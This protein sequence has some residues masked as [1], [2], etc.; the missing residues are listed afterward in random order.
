MSVPPKKLE[1]KVWFA[2]EVTVEVAAREAVRKEQGA[3]IRADGDDELV[4]VAAQLDLCT[5]HERQVHREQQLL[6][7]RVD[8]EG[9]VAR[10]PVGDIEVVVAALR[11]HRQL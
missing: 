3:S 1:K 8:A 7:V 2:L 4:V 5:R 11:E 10:Q 9:R 6:A